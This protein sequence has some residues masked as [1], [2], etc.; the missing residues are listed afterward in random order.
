MT[1]LL[2]IAEVSKLLA[3]SVM[4][5]RRLVDEGDLPC[6]RLRK[7]GKGAPL[8]FTQADVEKFVQQHRA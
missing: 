6:V 4:T 2:S 1:P 3:V 8:K 7:S 5:V